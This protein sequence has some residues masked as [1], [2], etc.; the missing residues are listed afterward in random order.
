[1][2]ILAIHT[3]T[4]AM[5]LSSSATLTRDLI[6]HLVPLVSAPVV[7]WI[8]ASKLH[9]VQNLSCYANGKANCAD[10]KAGPYRCWA[11]ALSQK[12][13]AKYRG[14]DQMPV[15]YDGLAWADI[16]IFSTSTRWGSHSSL[17]QRIIERMNT[18]ENR[19]VAY[20]EPYPLLGKRLGVVATGTD[21]R[22]GEAAHHLIDTLRWWGFAT[23]SDPYACA[24]A[25]QRSADPYYEQ[26]DS[27]QPHVARW[28]LTARGRDAV[29]HTAHAIAGAD[30][31]ARL[32]PKG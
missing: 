9:I 12:E 15:I 14:K 2:N 5:E 27:N 20:G 7:E 3:S 19:A 24:L 25:W 28:A 26:P 4:H 11:N 22:T 30:R 29:E 8:D 10:P 21:W 31:I 23:A 18:L 1:M 13:P 32:T 6:G 17:C 16:V